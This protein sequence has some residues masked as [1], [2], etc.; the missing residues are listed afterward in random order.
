ME[1]R[2]HPRIRGELASPKLDARAPVDAAIPGAKIAM[3]EHPVSQLPAELWQA[4]PV[5][6]LGQLSPR[7][8]GLPTYEKTGC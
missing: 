3:R 8:N 6:W 4:W 2:A 1:M 7:A 5:R